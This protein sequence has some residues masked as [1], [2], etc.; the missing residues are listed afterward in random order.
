MKTPAQR[1]ESA[2]QRA[3]RP[4]SQVWID[5][6]AED[7][8]VLPPDS[9]EPGDWRNDRAPYLIDIMRTMSP[10]SPWREGWVMKGVQVGG[11]SAGENFLGG[12]ICSAAGNI[13]VVFPTL[14]DAKQWELNRFTPMRDSTRALRLR[15]RD[16]RVR[17]AD[18]TKLRKKY[19]GGTM[20][21]VGA[22][23]MGGA[24][25]TTYRYIKFEE[26]DDYPRALA[27]QGN[28]IQ[29]FRNRAGNFGRKA[30]IWGDGTPTVDGQSA[31]QDGYNK[32][33]KREWRLWCPGGC[34]EAQPLSWSGFVLP[35][36]DPADVRYQCRGCNKPFSEEEWKTHNYKPR[37]KGCTEEQARDLGL[38]HWVAT[39]V[40]EP[41]VASWKLPSFV[42]PLG[43]RPWPVLVVEW[44]EAQKDEEK[45]KSFINNQM[46]ECWKDDVRSEVGADALQKRA[47]NYPLMYCPKG[48]LIVVAGVDTQD[49]RL[50]IVIRAFGRDEE[51]WGLWHGEIYGDPSLPDVWNKLRELLTAPIR[52]ESGQVLYVDAAAIDAGGHHSEDVYAFCRDA[53]LRGKHWFA[54]RGAKAY[55]APK[56]GRPKTIEFTWRGKA[57]PGGVVLRFLGTQA[58]KNLIDG[59]LRLEKTGGGYYHFP[60]GFQ[61]DYFEQLRSESRVRKKDKQGNKALWWEKGSKRNEA[62]D[63]EVYL[64]AALLYVMHGRHAETVWRNRERVFETVVQLDLLTSVQAP[65]EPATQAQAEAEQ[66]DQGNVTQVVV[67][68]DT[69]EIISGAPAADA[70]QAS[71]QVFEALGWP[72]TTETAPVEDQS[73]GGAQMYP[74]LPEPPVIPPRKPKPPKPPRPKRGG[75][76]N[77]WRK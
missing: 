73:Q 48:A 20:R 39:A 15:I 67:D 2:I 14:D 35:E 3:L 17:G 31:V 53:K 22:N 61:R 62:W 72:V 49:N 26:P 54:I 71:Q 12:S 52:H 60:L 64:Y 24:K 9:P 18:N 21:L 69:G 59:R 47:E 36:G 28:L 32:G 57:V 29:N 37:P 40:G 44:R 16:A 68:G 10:S 55:D 30:K 74:P 8:R 42:A 66:A 46:A 6:W 56:L 45:L 77:G 34:G 23:R 4:D 19:P 58:I 70:P 33:D 76:V 38:A 13:L 50:A 51:S 65:V 63:C 75:F 41:Y 11:S 1:F 27:G 25:S 5:E 43:W 7:N